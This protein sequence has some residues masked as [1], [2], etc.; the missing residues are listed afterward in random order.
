LSAVLWRKTSNATQTPE[1]ERF[2]ERILSIRETC[3]L[4]QQLHAYLV[5]VHDACLTGQPIPSPIPATPLAA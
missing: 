4:N 3:R 1:G 2:V 5:N